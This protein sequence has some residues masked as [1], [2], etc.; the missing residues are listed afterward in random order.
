[1]EGE[2]VSVPLEEGLR[3][4]TREIRGFLGELANVQTPS[5]T[6]GESLTGKD[7]TDPCTGGLNAR[8]E[9]KSKKREWGK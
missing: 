1:M 9:Q 3:R 7:G 5:E 8:A 2:T 4:L 6:E